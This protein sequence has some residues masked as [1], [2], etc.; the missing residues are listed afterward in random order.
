MFKTIILSHKALEMKRVKTWL[1]YKT[2][3]KKGEPMPRTEE[4]FDKMLA[5]D[6]ELILEQKEEIAK[7]KSKVNKL[8]QKV[9]RYENYY[10]V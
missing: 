4:Q 1:E 2:T 9:T 10:S 6:Q 5:M 8:Q 3:P 7:L